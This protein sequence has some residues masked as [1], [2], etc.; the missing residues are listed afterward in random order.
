MSD[1]RQRAIDLI[2]LALDEGTTLDERRNAAVKA[3]KYIDKHELLASPLDE[4]LGSQNKTVRAASTVLDRIMDPEFVDSVKTI[5]QQ[6]IR[7]G[8]GGESSSGRRRR[9][10]RR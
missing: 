4:L 6:F 8:G 3:V 5:G 7:R 1:P 10:R 2:E 9:R